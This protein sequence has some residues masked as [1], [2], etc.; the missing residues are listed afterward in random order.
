[1]QGQEDFSSMVD[2][3][4]STDRKTF[5]HGQWQKHGRQYTAVTAASVGSINNKD[6]SNSKEAS[7]GDVEKCR[8]KNFE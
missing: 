2:V 8:L 7:K 6:A 4:P 3:N 5:R 1:M